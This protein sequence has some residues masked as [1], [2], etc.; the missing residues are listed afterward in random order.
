MK[1]IEAI[2]RPTKTGD[3]YAALG[4]AGCP[5]LMMTEIEGQGRQKGVE[6]QFRGKTYK[7]ELLTKAKIEI[8]AN[9]ED[10]DRIVAV[11]R[12][13]ALTGK[14]GDGKIFVYTIEDAIQIRTGERGKM[15]I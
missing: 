1:K 12:E 15:T 3:V 5:G 2:I 8:V 6:Q 11:I 14:E 10:V 7:T 13:A 4:G 9:D